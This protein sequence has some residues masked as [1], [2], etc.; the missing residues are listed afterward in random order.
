MQHSLRFPSASLFSCMN[1]WRNAYTCVIDSAEKSSPSI[2][3][4]P[5]GHTPAK[6]PA[7]LI[8]LIG[9]ML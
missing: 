8:V 3:T 1:V 2:V 7:M 6:T 4:V 9:F 5:Q